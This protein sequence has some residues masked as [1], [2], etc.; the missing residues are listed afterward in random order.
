MRFDNVSILSL[1]QIEAPHRVPSSAIEEQLKPTM[2]RLGVHP[3]LLRALSGI[4]SRRFWDEGIMPS[5]VATQAAELAIER[6]G[7]D[8]QKL[9]ILINTSVCRD[10]IEPST[11][12]IV[13]G[14]L[15]LGQHCMNFDLANACLGFLNGMDMVANMIDR[16]QVDYGIVVDGEGS[17]FVT[18]QTVARLLDPACDDELF[19]ASFA[20]LTLGSGAAAMVLCRSDLAADGHRFRG[21]VNL[22]ATQHC[23]LCYGQP[24]HMQ[25]DTKA[26]LIAGLELAGKTWAAAS[27]ELAWS[28]DD[29][30]HF[31]MHQVSK[32]HTE[33]V[34]GVL[35]LDLAKI[36]AIYPE[37]GN[38]GPASIPIVLAKLA[39]ENKLAK[40]DRIALLGIGSGLNCT[41][42]EAVW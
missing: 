38:I 34:A 5:D 29:I 25:T 4:E 18:E 3:N 15:K 9:G 41:M 33:K 12:C 20:T 1:A 35:G 13:H 26:L 40:G 17:R 10:F 16:G 42:A 8:R 19:R 32:V 23:R 30:N 22:A 28:A 24:D 39:E 21:G 37:Y 14:N 2:D 27:A 36:Y 7:I 6:A 11:A 31:V